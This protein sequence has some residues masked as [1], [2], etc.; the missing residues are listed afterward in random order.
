VRD[1]IPEPL[2]LHDVRAAKMLRDLGGERLG[3]DP[4]AD[5]AADFGMANVDDWDL[6]HGPN[7][8]WLAGGLPK[9]VP[10]VGMLRLLDAGGQ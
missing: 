3:V 2:R 9:L 4:I 8:H 6:K 10:R 5:L 7:R 1:R